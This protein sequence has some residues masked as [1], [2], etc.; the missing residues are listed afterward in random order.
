[1]RFEHPTPVAGP[2]W[3]IRIRRHEGFRHSR[4]D[5]DGNTVVEVYPM[6]FGSVVHRDHVVL[7]PQDGEPPDVFVGHNG[8]HFG[9]FH[10]GRVVDGRWQRDEE[11]WFVRCTAADLEE[12]AAMWKD[13]AM[14]QDWVLFTDGMHAVIGDIVRRCTVC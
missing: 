6:N 1:M 8:P 11:V 4:R 2:G 7:N 9:R 13:P 3:S 5:S 12:L 14:P 10:R